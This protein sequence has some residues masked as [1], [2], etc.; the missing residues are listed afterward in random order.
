[1]NIILFDN[2][3]VKNFWPLTYNKPLALLRTGILTIEERWKLKTKEIV[4][5]HNFLLENNITKIDFVGDCIWVDSSIM[6]YGDII[7]SILKLESGSFLSDEFGFIAGRNQF[8]KKPETLSILYQNFTKEIQTK[9]IK[10]LEYPW[11]IFQ[12][13]DRTINEDFS[14]V[15]DKKYS[16]KI[17]ES[18]IV[19]GSNSIFIEEGASLECC[20]LNASNGPIYIGKNATIMEGSVVRGPFALCDN[21]TLKMGSKVYGATSLGPYCVGGGEIKNVIMMGYS[22]KAHEGYLGDSIIGEWCNL[23]AGTSCSNIKNTGGSIKLKN[24]TTNEQIVVGQKCGVIMGDYSRTAINS[25]INSG[26]IIGIC[27]NVF[28]EG[29]LPKNIENFTWG[30]SDKKSY[31]FK[32]ALTDINNWK[33]MKHVEITKQEIETLKFIYKNY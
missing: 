9:N 29:L 22:N 14:M 33:S 2:E 31:E 17:P 6:I 13:A 7:E 21:A 1:M 4:T 10:R 26:T 15:T 23:G 12:W 30:T 20:Y 16:Q 11:Q 27:C 18:T 5:S 19:F 25:S 3:K 32:K 8:S 24:N 28:G